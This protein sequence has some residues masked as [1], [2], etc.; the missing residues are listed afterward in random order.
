VETDI[1]QANAKI[2]CDLHERIHELVK[3]RSDSE[4][5]REKWMQAA[6]EF[7]SRFDDLAFPGGLTR[8]LQDLRGKDPNAIEMA[9]RFL[10]ADP[11]FFRSGYLKED[12]IKE[13]KKVGLSDA[14]RCRLQ[15]VVIRKINAEP[16]REFRRYCS[17]AAHLFD[18]QFMSK[19]STVLTHSRPQ[20][21]QKEWVLE[22]LTQERRNK[23]QKSKES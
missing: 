7:H 10:E 8:Q 22:R 18:E 21:K 14:Q 2:L 23:G 6:R 20:A 9:V 4:A 16:V 3:K 5:A 13:L 12:L 19:V 15:N 1:F 11:R 17:L